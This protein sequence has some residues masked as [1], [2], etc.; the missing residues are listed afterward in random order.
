MSQYPETTDGRRLADGHNVARMLGGVGRWLAVQLAT[1]ATGPTTEIYETRADAV[2][3]GGEHAFYIQVHP[4]HMPP[5]EAT[6]LLD[7]HRRAA[8]AGFDF[9]DPAQQPLAPMSGPLPT[10]S[11]AGRL[12]AAGFHFPNGMRVSNAR[13]NHRR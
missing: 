10:Q 12:L 11:A 4:G 5:A 1:G 3:H 6:A 8:A 13:R 2:R 7:L 9:T